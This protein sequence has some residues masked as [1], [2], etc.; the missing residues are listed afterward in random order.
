MVG[1]Y[2]AH[3]AGHHPNFRHIAVDPYTCDVPPM[4]EPHESTT[5]ITRIV[6]VVTMPSFIIPIVAAIFLFRLFFLE[7]IVIL[8]I[9]VVSVVV[10]VPI[11]IPGSFL[12]APLIISARWLLRFSSSYCGCRSV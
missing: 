3:G 8:A 9:P 1:L 2:A 7:I 12:V 10:L 11:R 4:L 5:F 6:V